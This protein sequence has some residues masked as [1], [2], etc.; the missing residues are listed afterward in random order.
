[1]R[2]RMTK[3]N[4]VTEQLQVGA[5]LANAPCCAC[6]R[7]RT[8]GQRRRAWCTWCAKMSSLFDCRGRPTES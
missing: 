2:T 3:L 7:A 1:M 4:S 6:L 8:C 5:H